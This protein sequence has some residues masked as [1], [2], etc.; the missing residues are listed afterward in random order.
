MFSFWAVAYLQAPRIPTSLLTSSVLCKTAAIKF[1]DHLPTKT[2]LLHTSERDT[3]L[4]RVHGQFASP[5]NCCALRLGQFMLLKI[6]FLFSKVSF[7]CS[8]CLKLRLYDGGERKAMK[9][10]F[11]YLSQ[12][13]NAL[14]PSTGTGQQNDLHKKCWFRCGW[15]ENWQRRKPMQV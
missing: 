14:L 8:G 10:I 9:V 11:V 4:W 12:G 6:N 3:A 1:S 5:N 15:A 7:V 2:P 13:M